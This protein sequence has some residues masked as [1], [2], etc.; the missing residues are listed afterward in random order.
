[1][2]EGEKTLDELKI[3]F[4]GDKVCEPNEESIINVISSE[5]EL[6]YKFIIGNDGVWNTIQDFSD[7]S[8]CKWIPKE[9]IPSVLQRRHSGNHHEY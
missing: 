8:A 3:S 9:K 5:E 4:N 1:M 7:K 2:G 6:E